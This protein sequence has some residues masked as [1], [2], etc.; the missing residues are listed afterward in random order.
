MTRVNWILALACL[1]LPLPASSETT[2]TLVLDGLSF[3]SFEGY[4]NVPLPPGSSLRFHFGDVSG[5]MAPFSLAPSDVTIPSIELRPGLQL[6]YAL[7]SGAT[8]TIQRMNGELHVEFLAT[9]RASLAGPDEGGA[10]DYALRFTTRQTSATN[11][12]QTET[13][14][15]DGSP[16]IPG[17]NYVQIVAGATNQPD[18]FPGPGAAVYGVLSG[19][20]DTLPQLP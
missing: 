7:V 13:I 6:T 5:S 17:P 12:A 15:V 9:V 4:E 3:I 10:R 18:A 2:G 20:F 8:G 16:V 11:A 19:S 1:V 14:E